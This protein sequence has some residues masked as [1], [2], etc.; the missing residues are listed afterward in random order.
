M[1]PRFHDKTVDAQSGARVKAAA[2]W[3]VPEQALTHMTDQLFMRACMR[4]VMKKYSTALS[5]HT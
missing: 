4:C 2:D 3:V 1:L 5:S